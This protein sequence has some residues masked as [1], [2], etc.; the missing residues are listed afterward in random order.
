[1]EIFN[2][3][4]YYNC[5]D[6]Y[7]DN[8]IQEGLEDKVALLTSEGDFTYGTVQIQANRMGN[9]LREVGVAPEQR[10]L[11]LL[12]DC[13]EFVAA[14]FGILKIG[15]VVVMINPD[16]EA[17]II[18]HILDYSRATAAIVHKDYHKKFQEI[19]REAPLLKHVHVV[20]DD[21]QKTLDA[22]SSQLENFPTHKN[23]PAIW[24][25]SGGTTGLPNAI[26]Q[27]HSSFINNTECYAK[28]VIQYSESDIT[29]SAPKLYFGYATGSNILFPFSVGA[30][31]ILFSDKCTA[32]ILFKKIKQ[33]K[34]TILINVPTM[35]SKMLSMPNAAEYDLSSLRL[36]TAAGE[37]LPIE[38]Y[39]RW[40]ALFDVE[41]LDGLGTSEMWHIFISNRPG[42]VRPGT[43][44]TVV[45]GFE[46]KICD[47]N[48][49]EVADGEPGRLWVRGNSKAIWYW[50]QIEKTNEVFRGEWYVSE[51]VLQRDS[52]GYFTYC[53][54]NDDMLKVGGKWL[55]PKEVENCLIQ[56]PSIAEAVVVGITDSSGLTKPYAFVA[57]S[58]TRTTFT[59]EL[60]DFVRERI[61]PYKCPRK[62]TLMKDLPRTHLG[63]IDRGR[64]RASV[65]GA[66]T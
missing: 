62:I 46:V 64:L 2:P 12:P 3:P 61:Q 21:T 51:D 47:E 54:R 18:Q 5:A 48:G 60:M 16:Q 19:S 30:T 57:T 25:F 37:A 35:I 20:G 9:M 53:G 40:K 11:I 58:E 41:I 66:N 50:P 38:L 55:S 26:V 63:K 43:L 36:S 22:F 14:L 6:Y 7:L 32:E 33:Y 65:I 28:Q 45:P 10:V 44:G 42:D 59:V 27:P 49:D 56:H 24:L 13:M 52:D 23:D 15:A 4:E 34:P 29:L 31:A 17:E 39:N 1:M 8:R